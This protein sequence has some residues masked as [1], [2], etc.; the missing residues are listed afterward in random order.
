MFVAVIATGF[1]GADVGAVKTPD[2]VMVPV[3]D[4]P[5]STPFTFHARFTRDPLLPDVENWMLCPEATSPA[6]GVTVKLGGCRKSELPDDVFPE[7]QPER[8]MPRTNNG[9]QTTKRC[10]DKTKE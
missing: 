8:T 1:F 2:D 3:E 4:E 7:A 5:P 10:L 6:F 9:Q